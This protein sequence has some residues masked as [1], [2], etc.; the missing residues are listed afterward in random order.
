M[1]SLIQKAV[2]SLNI[3]NSYT[4][5][6]FY[7]VPIDNET[8][9][10]PSPSRAPE[11][12]I[13][14]HQPSAV[15]YILVVLN[16]IC[17]ILNTL[18]IL[19]WHISPCLQIIHHVSCHLSLY[20][21]FY[22]WLHPVY[23]SC[24]CYIRQ[25]SSMVGDRRTLPTPDNGLNTMSWCPKGPFWNPRYFVKSCHPQNSEFYQCQP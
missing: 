20:Y 10:T 21:Q 14:K 7:K 5:S 6:L 12:I 4:N 17:L 25:R 2:S 22:L 8:N 23:H 1:D 13:V 3:G 19:S 16:S 24:D 11:S 18:W 15:I 9:Q